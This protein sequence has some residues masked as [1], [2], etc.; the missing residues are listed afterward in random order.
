MGEP[1]FVSV[2][3]VDK[4]KKTTIKIE[5]GCSFENNGAIYYVDNN[6][7]LNVYD[8]KTSV[9]SAGSEIKI[10]NYQLNTIK[11]I[12]DNTTEKDG[13]KDIS[14]I[15][16]SQMDIKAAM[17]QHKQGKLTDNLALLLNGTTYE[18]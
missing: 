12:A 3:L 5:K 13:D 9:W 6:G 2:D 17:S 11:A 4:K 10:K 14:G 8:K 7:N 16:L 1:N 18:A 15:V